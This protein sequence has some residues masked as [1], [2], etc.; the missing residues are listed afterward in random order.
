MKYL[1]LVLVFAL[2]FVT[3]KQEPDSATADTASTD[4]EVTADT[5]QLE[6]STRPE[7]GLQ[8]EDYGET[9][10]LDTPKDKTLFSFLTTNMWEYTRGIEGS[11]FPNGIVGKWIVFNE[12]YSYQTGYWENM[13]S[14]GTW[15]L[16]EKTKTLHLTP[17]DTN[18]RESQ[19]TIR[20]KSNS[21]VLSGTVKYGNNSSQ[22]F[23]ARRL[24]KPERSY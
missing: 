18:E 14:Q 5:S 7:Q 12:D 3:C 1:S 6:T 23:L 10:K 8:G 20:A 17:S 13:T 4:S 22:V 16:D 9:E 15:D 2:F 21:M 19:W 11:S 24:G